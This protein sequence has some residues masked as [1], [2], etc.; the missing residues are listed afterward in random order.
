MMFHPLAEIFPLMEG[1]EFETLVAD[2]RTHG[3]HEA[4]VLHDGKARWAK[5]ISRTPGQNI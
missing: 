2:I 1:E 4:V 5:P 3:L